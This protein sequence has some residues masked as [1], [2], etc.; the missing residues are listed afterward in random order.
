MGRS[1]VVIRRCWQV[2]V[3]NDRFQRHDGIGR[4]RAAAGREDRFIVRSAV[5]VP[6]SS[7]STIRRATRARVSTITIDRRLIERNLRSYRPLRNLPLT[8]AHCRARLQWCWAR[9]DWNHAD[10]GPIVFSDESRIQLCPDDYR[11]R[12][13]GDA[14]GSGSIL[15]SLLHA[16]QALNQKLWSGDPFLLTER[17]F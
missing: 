17:Y 4:P 10:R 15:L 11:R 13:S 16:T 12:V 2:W 9:S 5:T 7:L 8:P 14:H 3:Q 1:N 6:H